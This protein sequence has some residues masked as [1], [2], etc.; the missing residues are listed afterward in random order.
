[1]I[2]VKVYGGLGNQMFQYAFARYLAFKHKVPLKID[3]SVLEKKDHGD[4]YTVRDFQL[5]VFNINAELASEQELR[6]FRLKG[7]LSKGIDNLSLY[8]RLKDAV[9]LRERTFTFNKLY[10]NAPENAYVDGYWQSEKYFAEIRSILLN[11]FRP[12]GKVSD[13]TAVLA[14]EISTS[15]S[16]SIHVRRG[17]YISIKQNQGIYET[18][19]E[20]YYINAVKR[21]I[22]QVKD[23]VLYVFSDE[24]EWFK[25]H[26]QAPCRTVFVEHNTGAKSY[27]DIYLMSLC[28]HNI[29]ANSSFS[30][31]GAWLNRSEN[32]I[33]IAPKKWF[34]DGKSERDLICESWITI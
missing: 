6:K 26:I 18:C 4:N 24:P 29:I 19:S 22:E 7:K 20:E 25:Q 13:K 33:V 30:W 32:K 31:W 27:E 3:T 11:E 28:K 21:I 23:P 1:M 14:A 16:C 10:L 17:D 2:I 9:Y 12:S 5:K 15:D 8:L 34:R